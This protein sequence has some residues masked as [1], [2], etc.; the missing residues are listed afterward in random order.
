MFLKSLMIVQW[1]P[2]TI[3]IFPKILT[4][5]M[6]IHLRDVVGVIVVVLLLE[7]SQ[8]IVFFLHLQVLSWLLALWMSFL[9]SALVVCVSGWLKGWLK[10]QASR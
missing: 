3:L 8:E 9:A 2:T 1:A 7:V 5:S 6:M 4:V 10:I